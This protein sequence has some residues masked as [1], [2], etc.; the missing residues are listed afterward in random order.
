M[1]ADVVH[2]LGAQ[3]TF[4]E[5][6]RHGPHGAFALRVRG[7]HVMRIAAKRAP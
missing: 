5:S 2:L 1:S 3:P 7:S 4:L 6:P